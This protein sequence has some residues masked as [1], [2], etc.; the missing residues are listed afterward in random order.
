MTKA[1]VK[2]K[3]DRVPAFA[4]ALYN[5]KNQHKMIFGPLAKTER[6]PFAHFQVHGLGQQTLSNNI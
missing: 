4:E 2:A 5:Y 1:K 6:L 3:A